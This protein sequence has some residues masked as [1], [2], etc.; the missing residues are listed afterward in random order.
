MGNAIWAEPRDITDLDDCYFYHTM[1]IPGYGIV[2]GEWDLRG[3]E[4]DYL[5]KVR[6]EGKRVLEIGT[7]SGFLCFAMERM[8]ADV[9]TYDISD[10]QELDIV[11]YPGL[12]IEQRIAEWRKHNRRLNNGFWLAHRAFKSRARALHGTVYDIPEDIGRFDVCTFGSILLHVRDPF[13]AL[14]RAS[15][16]V[17]EAIIVTDVVPKL[18]G[19]IISAVELLTDS[20]LVRFVPNARKMKAPETWWHFSP[21][22]ISEYLQILGFSNIAISYHRQK[23]GT[24]AAKLYTV[25]GRRAGT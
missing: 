5:G 18:R 21:R 2:Q 1:E 8:G 3:G 7:A 16:H 20:R 25:V 19:K 10:E 23:C 24:R 22:L 4:A 6:L 13:L 12:D 15:S 9:V 14:Q 17:E 11:P